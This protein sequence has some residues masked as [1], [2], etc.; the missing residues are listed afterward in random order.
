MT[1]KKASLNANSHS[2]LDKESH[3][4]TMSGMEHTLYL[5]DRGHR[6]VWVY[7][8]GTDLS[9]RHSPEAFENFSSSLSTNVLSHK[10]P[11]SITTPST[12]SIRITLLCVEKHNLYP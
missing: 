12:R 11:S 6:Y 3:S 2:Q 1:E 5:N 8:S 7:D 10:S 4:C 9:G